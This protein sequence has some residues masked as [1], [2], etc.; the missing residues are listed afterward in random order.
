MDAGPITLSYT[1]YPAVTGP[2]IASAKAGVAS[3][4]RPLGAAVK[5]GL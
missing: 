3:G 1:F 2:R 4:T 5:A